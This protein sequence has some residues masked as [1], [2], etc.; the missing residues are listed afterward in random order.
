MSLS[1]LFVL[2]SY[3]PSIDADEIDEKSNTWQLNTKTMGHLHV[4]DVT[5]TKP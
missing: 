1:K 4:G 3:S 2:S 5:V